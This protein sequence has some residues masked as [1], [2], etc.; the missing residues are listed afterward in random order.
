MDEKLILR[1]AVKTAW[2]VYLATHGDVDLA[3]QRLCSLT[4]H[5]TARLHAGE[6]EVE[7]LACSGL[8]YLDRLP[9]EDE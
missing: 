9:E 7:E 3:D 2:S 1:E 5:L 6:T 4:R 8:A